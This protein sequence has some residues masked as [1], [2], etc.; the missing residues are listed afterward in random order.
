MK[1][2][3]KCV[4]L[5]VNDFEKTMDFYKGILRLPIKMQQDTYV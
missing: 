4:I 1:L 5:Y 3:M 2:S